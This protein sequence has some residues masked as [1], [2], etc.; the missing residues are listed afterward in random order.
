MSI[1][2]STGAVKAMVG[3]PD[4]GDSQYN[5]ATHPIG[6]QPG[7]TWK[8]I[9]LAA[10]LQNGYSPNDRVDGSSPCRVPKIF[11]APDAFTVNSGDGAGG[12]PMP[13]W[14]AT[15]G[16]VNCAYVRLS[17]SVGQSKVI[18]DG[19]RPRYRAVAPGP[20]DQFLTLSIGVVEA[21]PLEM[22]TVMA[23]IINDGVRKA[24]HVVA[25]VTD[26]DGKVLIDASLDPGV[27]V[28]DKEVAEL[29]GQHPAAHRHRRYRYR[30]AKL[31]PHDR[32][33]KTGT[34]DK[35]ADAW[36]LGGTAGSSRP[37]CGSGTAPATSPA[38][39]SV[40]TRRPRSSR[41]SW[42]RPSTASPTSVCPPKARY[43]HARASS[44][45]RTAA[46]RRAAP[47][48]ATTTPQPTV[49][50]RPTPTVPTATAPPATSPPA[51]PL[52]L[53]QPS[54]DTNSRRP[55]H[56][57]STDA[58]LLSLLSLQEHDTTLDR[59]RHRHETL[60][61]RDTLRARRKPR[62]ACSRRRSTRSPR[63]ATSS[64]ARSNGSTTK[65]SRSREKATAVDKKMYSGEIS[66]PKELQA[67][68][69]DIDQLQR[70]QR[71]VENTELELMEQR[72][73]LDASLVELAARAR[74]IGGESEP[75][76]HGA[77][78]RRAGDRRR[79]RGRAGGA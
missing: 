70:H 26:P 19:T 28:L 15:A 32:C 31:R 23:T 29:R 77:G 4:F 74:R 44:S 11:P 43:A 38:P 62:S 79:S 2:P 55:P 69:A 41:R 76:P 34:T 21:T 12:G 58:G 75:R 40:A 6:R 73:P 1:E 8:V 27:R 61:E 71:I 24:P 20:D 54:H 48:P 52:H 63:S 50:V 64:R 39:A 51:P 46:A 5:I 22:A 57:M 56:A 36:F 17:T 14:D 33:G 65:P 53:V 59:L 68:Q 16:S 78:S 7:S 60:P 13:I 37:R 30:R 66:S 72:E 45:T 42:T 9:T 18:D 35:G 47:A 67:M 10:A 25:K 49:Q 3:G